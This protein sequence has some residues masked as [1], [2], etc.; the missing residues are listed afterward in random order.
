MIVPWKNDKLRQVYRR[1]E[2]RA[3]LE[4]I[5]SVFTIAFLL[6]VVIRPT[7]GIVAELQKKITD[8]DLVDKKMTSKISQLARAKNDLASFGG[9]LDLFYRAVTDNPETSNLAKRISL[10]IQ[11]SGLE[12][13]S[14]TIGS[15]PILGKR[16]NLGNKDSKVAGEDLNK[17]RVVTGTKIAFTEISFDLL[18]SQNQA[19]VFLS[20]LEKIDRVVKLNNVDIKRE[21]QKDV[22]Q[23]KNFKGV[24]LNGKAVVYY[25]LK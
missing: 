21:E 5:F 19:L 22:D 12:I 3:S 13:N 16:I 20:S 23:G 11:E 25:Q 6:M 17:P 2:I 8:Q 18:G 7:I 9:Q 24:R 14:F 15:V 10:L 4:I 1:P